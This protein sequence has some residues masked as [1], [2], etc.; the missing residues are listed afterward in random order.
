[1]T[2]PTLLTLR[3]ESVFVLD[4]KGENEKLTSDA[5]ARLAGHDIKIFDI[6]DPA[7]DRWNLFT[8]VEQERRPDGT[9]H[10]SSRDLRRRAHYIIHKP[11]KDQSNQHWIHTARDA[12]VSGAGYLMAAKKRPTTLTEVL[13]FF[14]D[15]SGT[16]LKKRLRNILARRTDLPLFV[17]QGFAALVEK[18]D[19]EFGSVISTLTARLAEYAD[20]DLANAT[21]ASDFEL[22][23]LMQGDKP[24]TLYFKI[25]RPDFHRVAPLVRLM[26]RLLMDSGMTVHGGHKRNLFLLLDEFGAFEFE[27]FEDD[28]EQA[29]G[30][31]IR[32]MFILQAFDKLK[33]LYGQHNSILNNTKIQ[34]RFGSTDQVV[35]ESISRDCGFTTTVTKQVNHS[36]GRFGA[37]LGNQMVSKTPTKRPLISADEIKRIPWE[38]AIIFLPRLNPYMGW[39]KPYL[40]KPFR[41]LVP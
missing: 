15:P 17:R 18:P 2:V 6:I 10:V 21:G 32:V 28:L 36:G 8:S 31:G 40:E 37:F 9:Y 16:P 11:K 41:H 5:R 27:N 35:A 22:T 34:V 39:K 12:F 29:R 24:I 14:R 1:M 33:A 23:D 13:G 3:Q 19:E 38:R 7:T 26:Y 20:T 4:I 25:R 30:Y